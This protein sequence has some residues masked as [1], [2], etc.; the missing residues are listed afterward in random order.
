MLLREIESNHEIEGFH[1]LKLYVH[2]SI[3]K[4]KITTATIFKGNHFEI[5]NSHE[6]N[7]EEKLCVRYFF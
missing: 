2:K 7:N 6:L 5:K 1:E 3:N 4:N